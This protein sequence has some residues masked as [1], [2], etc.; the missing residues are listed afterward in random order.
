MWVLLQAM[1]VQSWAA[2]S[3]ILQAEDM[4]QAHVAKELERQQSFLDKMRTEVGG[5]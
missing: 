4:N 3:G 5:V 1:L 2:N